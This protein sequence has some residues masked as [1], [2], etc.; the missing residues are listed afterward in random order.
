MNDEAEIGPTRLG[1][2]G[3]GGDAR[4]NVVCDWGGR[5]MD[6]EESDDAR[7]HYAESR[8]LSNG[9]GSTKP[10]V[11]LDDGVFKVRYILGELNGMW[12]GIPLM[13]SMECDSAYTQMRL[14]ARKIE[15]YSFLV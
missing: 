4:M 8:G 13:I 7:S 6:D 2:E 5:G 15:M 3:T 11:R 1:G 10:L 12:S 14:T 9:R